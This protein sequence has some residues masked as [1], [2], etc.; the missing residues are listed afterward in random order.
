MFK[1][2]SFLTQK[3]DNTIQRVAFGPVIMVLVLLFAAVGVPTQDVAA[4]APSN[5][6]LLIAAFVPEKVVLISPEGNIGNNYNP[7]YTWNA[8]VDADEYTLGVVGPNGEDLIYQTYDQADICT[9]TI[10]SVTHPLTLSGGSHTWWVRGRN[11]DGLGPWSD[12]MVFSIAPDTT[13]TSNPPDPSFSNSA[14]FAFESDDPSATFECQLDGGGFSACT[15]PMDYTG[16]SDSSHTFEVRAVESHGTPDPTPASYTWLVDVP[17]CYALTLSHTGNG[18]DPSADPANSPGCSAG[19]FVEGAVVDLTAAPNAGWQ[20]SSWT[21]TNDNN[22]TATSNT[23]TMPAGAHAASV[24]YTQI[25][26]TLTV[27]TVGNGTVTRDPDQAIYHYGDVVQ[28]TATPAIGWLF[29]AWSGSLTSTANPVNITIDANETV[30]ATFTQIEYTLTVNTV[31]NGT[32][33]RDP[34]QATYHYGD[35]VQLTAA[36]AAGSS[37]SGWSGDLTGSANPVNITIDGNKSVTA[38][39]TNIGYTLTVNIVGDGTVS[40]NPDQ[41]F[42]TYGDVVELTAAPMPGWTFAGWSGGLSGNAN[43]ESIVIDEDET[44]TA[45]FLTLPLLTSPLN[46]TTLLYNQPTFDWEDVNGAINYSIQVS[47]YSNFRLLLVNARVTTSTYTLLRALPVNTVLYWRVKANGVAFNLWSEVRTLTSANPPSLPLLRSPA[48]NALVTDYTPRLDWADVRLPAGTT[49]DKYELQMATDS[50]FTSPTSVEIGGPETNSEY[51]PGVDLLPNTRYY[52]RVRAYN[53]DGQYSAWSTSRSF[54]TAVLP[55]TLL[56]PSD[57][58]ILLNKRPTFDWDD[59]A[60]AT[61]Y[62]IQISTAQNFMPVKINAT[63]TTSTFT[64]TIN[65]MADT[66]YYWRV[67]TNAVNGPSVFSE[68]WSFTTGNPPS[69]PALVAPANN[70]L[71]TDYTPLLNWSNSTLPAG[72]TFDHYQLQIATDAAF[73]S[74]VVDA[75]VGAGDITASEY[76]PTTDL[77]ANTKFYWRVRAVNSDL[78]YSAWSVSRYF[79]TVLLPPTLVTP[80]DLDILSG[81][82]PTFDWEDVT[83]ASSYTIQVSRNPTFTQLVV[84]RTVATSTYTPVSNLPLNITLY[85]RVRTNGPNGPSLWSEVR[86]FTLQ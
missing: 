79:R 23:V 28:L 1:T 25:E 26:Y 82:L 55:P 36:P 44:V 12:P 16:L 73:A 70:A 77:A 9:A 50:A 3:M 38:T 11:V 19:Q 74:L 52:W 47:R 83:G 65:L 84:N 85:W 15:S 39:F 41:A 21:G 4:Q 46:G 72:T 29:S 76:S 63:V 34:D 30:T 31:G 51:T 8:L 43:P 68:V 81:P 2:I 40:R 10:C 22:S 61:S 58:E 24:N 42:Y 5:K 53:T 18:S 45:Q 6:P 66:L 57:A 69:T 48:N 71:L 32:V 27:N 56:A 62:T 64:P 7:T 14:T 33:T 86:S 67:R 60:G 20:V 35:V 13:I 49:F 78:E 80:A 75:N 37:F 59:V 54:R 17:V